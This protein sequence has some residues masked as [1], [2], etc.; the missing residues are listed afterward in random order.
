MS[1]PAG[2]PVIFIGYG[3]ADEQ[4]YAPQLSMTGQID[5]RDIVTTQRAD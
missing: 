3:H 4:T 1:T 2:K 5:V